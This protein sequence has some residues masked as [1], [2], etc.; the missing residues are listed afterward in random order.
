MF[1][2]LYH[3]TLHWSAHRHAERALFGISFIESSVFP[4]PP[5]ILLIPM[6][7]ANRARAIRYAAICTIAS[8]LGGLLGYAIGLFL[9]ETI[10]QWVLQFYGLT[11]AFAGFELK[12]QQWGWWLVLM[13][14][15]TPFP[16]KVITIASGV[17][18]LNIPIFIAA[19]II[20]RGGRF[21]IEAVLLYH[22]GEKIR[23]FIDRYFGLLTILFF[24]LL[25]GG[26]AVIKLW[27]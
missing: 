12:F 3:W 25:L 1:K 14:G 15:F 13:A 9:F 16:Y 19:S 11:D 6:C 17:F 21:F 10:G 20:S 18:H 22:Y 27:V 4:I 23:R 26:F 7:L 8:V 5:D 24:V 2:K